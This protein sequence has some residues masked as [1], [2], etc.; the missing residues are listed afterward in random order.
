MRVTMFVSS[1]C[2]VS[3]RV[4]IPNPFDFLIQL[5]CN[6]ENPCFNGF[7]V[8]KESESDYKSLS[9]LD[10]FLETSPGSHQVIHIKTF[11]DFSGRA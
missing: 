9:T 7:V 11:G 8:N 5:T 10:S 2:C 6:N 4:L 1:W 3:W